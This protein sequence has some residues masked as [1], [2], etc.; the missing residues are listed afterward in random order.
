MRREIIRIDEEKCTGC[1][2]C[3]PNCPEGALQ[4][5]NGKAR[6]VGDLLCDGLGACIGHCPEG[7]ISIEKREAEK[8]DEL[9]VI[10]NVIKEGPAAIKE[11]LE[12]LKEHG[13]NE[14]LAQA[15]AS[16]KERGI[17]NP[18]HDPLQILPGTPAAGCGC[19]GSRAID[20]RKGSAQQ[21]AS[22]S[23]AARQSQLRQWP[24]QI[25]LVP[26][27]APYFN[28]ADV[29]LAADCVPFAYPSFHEQLLAGKVLLVGCPKLDNAKFYEQKITEI[30]SRNDIRSVTVAFMEVPCC[31]GMVRLAEAAIGASGKNLPLETVKLGIRG[32]MLSETPCRTS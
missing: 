3:I 21:P 5:V 30:L 32:D 29:L 6:L 8:Y 22:K 10:T 13:Q 28:G 16:L 31:M 11:H 9:K 19:P 27:T 23:G 17:E 25:M 14:Y 15:V 20:L 26:P 4:I 7:A 24:V 2:E 18:L 12:H 1:G